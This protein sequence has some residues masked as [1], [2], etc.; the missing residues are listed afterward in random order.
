MDQFVLRGR[1]PAETLTPFRQ[2][3]AAAQMLSRVADDR[4]G[5]TLREYDIVGSARY[6]ALILTELVQQ[7]D[8]QVSQ[9]AADADQSRVTGADPDRVLISSLTGVIRATATLV[10]VSHA[11]LRV[12]ESL[13]VVRTP[14]ARVE[15]AAAVETLRAAVGT[16]QITIQANLGRVTDSRTYDQL[17]DGLPSFDLIRDHADKVANVIRKQTAPMS[18]PAQRAEVAR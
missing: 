17:V 2:A 8:E 1:G 14:K 15:L 4:T 7:L 11:L 9:L 6:Q 3:M 16:S 5:L 13:L 10:E 12:G 18:L